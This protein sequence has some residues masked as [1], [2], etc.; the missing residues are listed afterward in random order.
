MGFK[1]VTSATVQASGVASIARLRAAVDVVDSPIA[2]VVYAD[3]SR[4]VT[5]A[6]PIVTP[7]YTL[8]VAD[9]VYID[10]SFG[11]VLDSTGR[12][13]FMPDSFSIVDSV[14]LLPQKALSDT[15]ATTTS[16]VFSA[17]KALANSIS[18]AEVLSFAT[19]K[20]LADF[21]SLPDQ[22]IVDFEKLRQDSFTTQDLLRRDVAKALADSGAVF[23][24]TTTA[25]QKL[26]GDIADM[27]DAISILLTV[28]RAVDDTISVGDD[29][30]WVFAL[31]PRQDGVALS[32][33]YFIAYQKYLADGFAMNDGS[34][35]VDGAVYSFAKGISNVTFVGDNRSLIFAL[36][37]VESVSVA[38]VGLVSAQNYCD[39]TYFAEDYVGVSQSF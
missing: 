14:Q 38:D 21:V 34:E 25:T 37:R 24:K 10:L 15:T 17:L 35:A 6:D 20:A 29:S 22:T 1:V 12:F 8:P 16:V 11:A 7:A 31:A 32:D 23:D 3:L 27:Q 19:T 26:L 39:P 2:S 33:V 13:R 36:S 28:L 18:T 30:S 4:A 9:I 5:Y